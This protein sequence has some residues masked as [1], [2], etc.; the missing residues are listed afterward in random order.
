MSEEIKAGEA[1]EPIEQ[2]AEQPKD[3]QKAGLT[4][5]DVQKAIADALEANNRKWQSNF[6]KVLSEKRTVEGK[7]L[8]V[9]QRLEQIEQERQRE[10]L[11]WSR[12]EAKAKAQIDDE[13]D[14]AIRLYA[15]ADSEGI[16]TGAVKIRTMIDA[17][18]KIK[19]EEAVKAALE[20]IGSQPAPKGGSGGKTMALAEFQKLGAKEQ[21]A[22]FNAGGQLGE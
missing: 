2:A 14:E 21:A 16:A 5:D 18:I 15:G 8:T 3:Q 1:Q 12:K 13:L 6:D 4:S 9:E 20:K 10:R 11:D 19:S 7:A 17:L 22:F